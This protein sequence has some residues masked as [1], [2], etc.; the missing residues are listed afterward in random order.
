[1]IK[2]KVLLD[3]SNWSGAKKEP[4]DA[5]YDVK[6]VGDFIEDPGDE[7][8]IELAFTEHR[9]LITL[10]KDFGELAIFKGKPHRGIIRIVD[11]SALHHG[12]IS[13]SI[14]DKY[15]S[16]LDHHAVITAERD[17]VRIRVA[18]Y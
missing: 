8:V 17:R 4:T 13:L 11:F 15:A 5:G 2:A 16:E 6:G 1:M 7:I 12:Q 3:S 18:E 9:I 10:D 14:L